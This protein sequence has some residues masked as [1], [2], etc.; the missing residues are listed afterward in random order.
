MGWKGGTLHLLPQAVLLSWALADRT[1]S[2]AACGVPCIWSPV[3]S[4][5]H[6]SGV[7]SGTSM[8]RCDPIITEWLSQ[9]GDQPRWRSQDLSAKLH[10]WAGRSG[11]SSLHSG[12]SRWCWALQDLGGRGAWSSVVWGRTSQQRGQQA[13]GPRLAHRAVR[14]GE[15]AADVRP[16]PSV[17]PKSQCEGRG[18]CSPAGRLLE[19]W[20]ASRLVLALPRACTPAPQHHSPASSLPFPPLGPASCVCL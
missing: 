5:R 11:A 20:A 7:G 9:S 15:E 8:G 13:I 4:G 14:A 16:G 2:L 12:D 3:K 6:C 10:L 17:A 1:D 18:L 19:R